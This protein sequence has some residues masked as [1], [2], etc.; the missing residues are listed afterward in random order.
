MADE[1]LAALLKRLRGRAKLSQ[2]ELAARAG[3]SPRTVSDI[4]RGVQLHPRQVTLEIL[5]DALGIDDAER[6]EL[7]ATA[8]SSEIEPIPPVTAE[9]L[10]RDRAIGELCST[11]ERNGRA[12]VTVTGAPGVGKTVLARCVAAAL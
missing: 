10:G 8:S 9:L 1:H 7:W 11:F 4:E 5:S 3:L 6:R 12:F 2:E